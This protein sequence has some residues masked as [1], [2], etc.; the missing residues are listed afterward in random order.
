MSAQ[1]TATDA[2]ALV[3]GAGGARGIAHIHALKAFD[4]LGVKPAIVAGTSI[5]SIF[6]ASYCAGMTGGQIEEYVVERFNDRIRLITEAFKVR[7]S[8]FKSF[9]KDGGMRLG[10][11]NLETILTVFL[12]DEV[13]DTFE[14]L[15]IPL[16]IAATDYYA[17]TD[18]LFS[19]GDLHKAV[20]ASAAM[21]A[22]FL[23]VEL[24]GR[25]YLDGSSTNPCP[26]NAVQGHASHVIAI[27]VSGGPKGRP[28]MRPSKVD[29]MYAT[30]QIM[31]R[32]IAGLMAQSYPDTILLRPPVD[33]IRPLDFLQTK[34]ILSATA[35]LRE[36]VKAALSACFEG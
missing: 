4:D 31:Q 2:V 22:V 30:S 19:T 29:V 32:T 20:A 6:G 9:L 16:L 23:P 26:I 27:D 8:S 25:Y 24:G 14:E 1:T 13:P 33:A 21:P 10:E 3:L 36:E 5:G 28:D 34:E 11:L 35:P 18:T 17:S 12:P 15:G 7:P